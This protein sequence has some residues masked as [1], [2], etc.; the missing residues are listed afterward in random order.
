M[1]PPHDD[2]IEH[3]PTTEGMRELDNL[4]LS[5]GVKNT[6]AV[7]HADSRDDSDADSDD[8]NDGISSSYHPAHHDHN[9]NNSSAGSSITTA[10]CLGYSFLRA[11]HVSMRSFQKS[12][13]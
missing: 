13:Y 3:C 2:E 10:Y 6:P 1:S 4:H 9:P 8:D 5:T 12:L 7:R 11:D